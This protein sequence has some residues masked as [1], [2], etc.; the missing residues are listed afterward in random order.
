M[1]ELRQNLAT[2][3][4]VIISTERAKRPEEFKEKAKKEEAEDYD[5]KCPFC[6]GNEDQT[7]SELMAYRNSHQQDMPGWR[8]RVVP[9]KFPALVSPRTSFAG[10]MRSQFAIYNC[11]EGVGKHEVII[12]HPKHNKT[13]GTLSVEETC[14]MVSAY[15]DRYIDVISNPNF[16]MVIIFRNQGNL[17]GASLRHPHSQ[18]VATPVVPS[19]I[20]YRLLE[21]QRY[22]DDFGRCVYCDILNFELKEKK[23]LILENEDFVAFCPYAAATPYEVLIFPRHHQSSF[24]EMEKAKI[25]PL[26]QIL[27]NVLAKIYHSLN[28]PDYNYVINTAPHYSA[29]EPHFHWNLQILPR[30]STRA[31]FEIGSGISINVSLPEE[32]ARFLREATI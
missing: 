12:E 23:R 22:F 18:L 2:K 32:T 11:M 20:R 9:N 3:E 1:P 19:Y 15:R 29:G 24:G 30:L 27:Q 25:K 5:E 7:G 21:A 31:G 6:E 8:V 10:V 28:N 13:V 26:A 17:A 16:Q 4:W 14:L